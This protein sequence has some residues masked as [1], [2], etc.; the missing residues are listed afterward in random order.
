[1]PTPLIFAR[2]HDH[3]GLGRRSLALRCRSGELTRLRNGVYARTDLWSALS[4]WEQYRLHVEAAVGKGR[5]RRI[6]VQ[7][8]SAVVWGIPIVGRSTEVQL[9]A[10]NGV[11]GKR[12]VRMRWHDLQLLEPLGEVEGFLATGRAQ[13]VVDMAADLPFEEA[14]PA[15][16]HVLGP[17]LERMLPA[18][19]KDQLRT[20]AAGLPTG[21]KRRRALKVIDFA[22]PRSQSPGE[23]LSRAQMYLHHF[24]GP[25]LQHPVYDGTGRLL[26]IADFYWK[27]HRLIGEFDGSVKYSRAEFL[28][29]GLPADALERE[30]AREDRIRAT[31]LRF[32]RWTWVAAFTTESDGS[33]GLVRLLANAGLKQ[34]RWNQ[35][36]PGMD[37]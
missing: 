36:W 6:L 11:H 29:V 22:D 24:P 4:W 3:A 19:H 7:Q 23:S 28:S 17:D 21:T 5:T 2:D 20:L 25:E 18:L 26:G 35:R 12:R 13:T 27:E 30:K 15:M 8:S 32:V 33:P 31:G 37:R 16:D 9:L 34:D 1:M 14:V 10:T